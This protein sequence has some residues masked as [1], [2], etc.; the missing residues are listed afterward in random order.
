M[1]IFK[2][3]CCMMLTLAVEEK[4]NLPYDAFYI[5]EL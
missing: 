3:F 4:N 2:A 1:V 5:R